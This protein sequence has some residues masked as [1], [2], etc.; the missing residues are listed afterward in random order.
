M[1][2][3][4][5][6]SYFTTTV[7]NRKNKKKAKSKSQIEHE[8]WLEKRGLL[9]AQLKTKKRVDIN[10]Q[11]EYSKSIKVERKYASAEMTGSRDS[12]TKKDIMSNL[13]KEPEHVRKEILDKASRVMPLYNKGGLQY[14]TPE[15][16]MKTVGTKSRRG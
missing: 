7:S 14:A 13:H 10:W 1:T 15:T 2:M 12:C 4:L 16:D 11:D 9:P 3:H 8:K 6:P 5:L